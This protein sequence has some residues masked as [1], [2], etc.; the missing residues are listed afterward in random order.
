[1]IRVISR[2][3][4]LARIQLQEVC[5][6]LPGV[7]F[8]CSC[9]STF[10]DAHREIPLEEN[11]KQDIF[12]DV[13]DDMILG[14]DADIAVH[15]AKDVPY[16]LR[17]GLEVIALTG[18]AHRTDA[19]VTRDG[20]S[21]ACLPPGAMVGISSARR[22]KYVQ[23]TRPDIHIVSIRGNIEERI[24]QVDNGI[25]DAVIIATCA[26]KR[27]NLFHRASEILPV[28]TH[29]LQGYL[30]V[31]ARNTRPDLRVLFYRIDIRNEWG[32]VWIV[33]AGPGNPELI[34][35]KAYCIVNNA[36]VVLYDSLVDTSLLSEC[37]GKTIF[38]GKRKGHA[39]CSQEE[40]NT[41]LCETA[42][43]GKTVVRLKG[44]DPMI[45][46]RGGEEY[47]F[48]R[49]HQV[50][51]E[52]VP[53]ISASNA[54]AAWTGIPLTAR[55]ISPSVT[56]LSGYHCQ[57]ESY[58][59]VRDGTYV[60]Y[61]GTSRLAD[62]SD[63]LL[64]RGENPATPVAIIRNL[65]NETDYCIIS[66]VK[67]MRSLSL[68]PPAVIIIGDVVRH[69]A[70]YPRLL[71][72]GLDPR[73]FS[74]REM[75]V[76][77][78]LIAVKPF[79]NYQCNL[80]AY[81]ACVFTSRTAVKYFFKHFRPV[82]QKIYAIGESTASELR[83][84]GIHAVGIPDMPDSD[85][86]AEMILALQCRRML[87]PCSA[88]A[89]NALHELT[90]VDILPLYTTINIPQPKIDLSSFTG[91]VFTSPST[92]DAFLAIY[93]RVPGHLAC[94]VFGKHTERALLATGVAQEVIIKKLP[95]G[96]PA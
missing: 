72:T 15:S 42:R 61:M 58:V 14:G 33:G 48:L 22:K 63:S 59:S 20:L 40:I 84:Y 4:P 23:A 36:D 19:L 90:C 54:A 70:P 50:P 29:P 83:G 93:D 74:S 2:A 66:S 47:H 21:L 62:I 17:P 64:K 27:L 96:R 60:Y 11:T 51:V 52:I 44:G 34:T 26:L 18:G 43:S 31:V 80:D 73:A 94:F 7:P 41:T 57:S 46:G 8:T 1:M 6:Q 16:P 56:F 76:H 53:G 55:G 32:K 86:L 88:R 24:A 30:S 87:Y 68:E 65:Y 85:S 67:D 39:S 69:Y 37:N 28:P 5:S 79:D 75:L 92:I 12:T 10:G 3:S 25:L 71:Y 9:V 78:P 81:D 89:K 49:A 77:Y 35:R 13:L 82:R 95:G 38:A 45:F 91:V